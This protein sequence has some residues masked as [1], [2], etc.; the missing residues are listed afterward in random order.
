ML[1]NWGSITYGGRGGG[2]GGEGGGTKGK[3][4]NTFINCSSRKTQVILFRV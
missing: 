2:G 1:C 4:P 3:D